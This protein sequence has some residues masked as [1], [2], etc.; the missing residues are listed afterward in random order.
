MTNT[1]SENTFFY[2]QRMTNSKN[3]DY[4]DYYIGIIIDKVKKILLN[5]SGVEV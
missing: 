2:E 1:T 3:V 5:C 4:F